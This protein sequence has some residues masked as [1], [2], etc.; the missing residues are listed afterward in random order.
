MKAF[1]PKSLNIEPTFKRPL[2]YKKETHE[3][4][5][6]VSGSTFIKVTMLKPRSSEERLDKNKLRYGIISI[7]SP[8]T[9][10]YLIEFDSHKSLEPHFHFWRTQGYSKIPDTRSVGISLRSNSKDGLIF[11]DRER[12]RE[13]K[14]NDIQKFQMLEFVEENRYL[15]FL[16]IMAF[17]A[18]KVKSFDGLDEQSVAKLFSP[19]ELDRLNA[20]F[21]TKYIINPTQ[22]GE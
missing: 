2:Y 9:N 13:P 20:T 10:D 4:L 12:K 14:T 7:K 15:L 18:G 3:K 17:R 11:T 19:R 6:N 5:K 21:A 22:F 8:K 1:Y 16:M